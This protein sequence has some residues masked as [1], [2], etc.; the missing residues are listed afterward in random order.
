MRLFYHTFRLNLCLQYDGISK[1]V[2]ED[3]PAD[4]SRVGEEY[5]HTLDEAKFE[6]RSDLDD[7]AYVDRSRG[8]VRQAG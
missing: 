8:K 3:N 2:L 6:S 7:P 1:R 5:E 4:H